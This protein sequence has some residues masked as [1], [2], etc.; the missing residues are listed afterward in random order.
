MN[1]D[2][3][4]DRESEKCKKQKRSKDGLHMAHIATVAQRIAKGE[5]KLPDLDLDND[6]QYECV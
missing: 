1:D 6:A 5:I 2:D 4:D 3:F